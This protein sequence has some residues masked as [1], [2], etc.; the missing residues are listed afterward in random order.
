[1]DFSDSQSLVP[2]DSFWFSEEF[3]CLEIADEFK[4]GFH[5]FACFFFGV[6]YDCDEV[7]VLV[8]YQLSVEHRVVEGFV[9]EDS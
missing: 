5:Q 1:M 9:A 3:V 6:S 7:V 8:A 2:G 4:S